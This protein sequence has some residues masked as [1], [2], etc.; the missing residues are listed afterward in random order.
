MNPSVGQAI[1]PKMEFSAVEDPHPSRGLRDLTR[2]R[3]SYIKGSN[4]NR[5]RGVVPPC[6]LL[7]LYLLSLD[8]SR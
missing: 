7:D 2:E 5:G 4:P 6:F 8:L 1:F 3:S